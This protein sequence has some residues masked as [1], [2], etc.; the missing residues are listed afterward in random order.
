LANPLD[1]A[2][3]VIA[4]LNGIDWPIDWP[5]GLAFTAERSHAPKFD[6]G[7]L[8]D[9]VV[10][11]CARSQKRTRST[12]LKRRV[13]TVIEVGVMQKLPP[14]ADTAAQADRIEELARLT[15]YLAEYFGDHPRPTS[16]PAA[17]ILDEVE[18]DPLIDAKLLRN[19][20]QFACVIRLPIE[21]SEGG[22]T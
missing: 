17:C 4:E 9:L 6:L 10:V 20:N 16:R 18:R 22:A 7:Q 2:D 1:I 11:V 19:A 21:E 15:Q 12:R 14:A 3:A 13:S 5:P 8:A